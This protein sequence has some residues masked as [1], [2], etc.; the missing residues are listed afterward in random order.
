[1][2]DAQ[3]Y[4]ELGVTKEFWGNPIRRE[5]TTELTIGGETCLL[6]DVE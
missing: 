2:L 3:E 4:N 5:L 6:F 1:M